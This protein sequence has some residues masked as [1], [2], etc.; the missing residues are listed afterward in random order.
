[1]A[2]ALGNWGDSAA[3][4]ALSK[5]LNDHEALIRGHAAWAL[6]RIGGVD[7]RKALERR[8]TVEDDDWVREEVEAALLEITNDE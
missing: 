8:L 6:G 2:V 7:A 5:A 4:S 1:V 3:V